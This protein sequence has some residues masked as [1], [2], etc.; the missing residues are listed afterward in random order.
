MLR[1]GFYLS[2]PTPTLHRIPTE[3]ARTPVR[4][5]AMRSPGPNT[6]KNVGAGTTRLREHNIILN[7]TR[8]VHTLAQEISLRHVEATV[9]TSASTT[10]L[11]SSRQTTRPTI[12]QTLHLQG[13]GE[14]PRSS[15]R[16]VITI[17]LDATP[18]ERMAEHL[19]VAPRRFLKR[20]ARLNIA[21]HNV[22]ILLTSALS[23]QMSA[24]AAT[25]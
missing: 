20:E 14:L 22:L 1:R 9:A 17:T 24:I 6:I 18:K 8:N 4:K 11:P 7:R 15:S 2:S 5:L 3:N 10:T 12:S 16:S 19:R 21:L 13:L 25:L 23:M